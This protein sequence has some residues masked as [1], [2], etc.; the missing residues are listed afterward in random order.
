MV[1]KRS[2]DDLTT[3]NF[4]RV[5]AIRPIEAQDTLYITIGHR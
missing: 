5:S 2:I 3:T 1:V 4:H